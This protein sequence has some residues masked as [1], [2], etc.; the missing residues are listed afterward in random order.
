MVNVYRSYALGSLCVLDA[1]FSSTAATA[2]NTPF[3]TYREASGIG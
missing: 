2:C 3:R 1:F